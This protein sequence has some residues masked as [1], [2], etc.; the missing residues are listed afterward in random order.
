MLGQIR[1][2][3]QLHAV[4]LYLAVRIGV[5]AGDSGIDRYLSGTAASRCKV[6]QVYSRLPTLS[7]NVL[8]G[9]WSQ[10]DLHPVIPSAGCPQPAQQARDLH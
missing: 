5:A 10:I 3:E 9:F 2:N 4:L 1:Q 8:D 6:N 7:L